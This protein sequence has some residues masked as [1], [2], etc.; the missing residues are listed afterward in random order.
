MC[1]LEDG[2]FIIG[3]VIARIPVASYEVTEVWQICQG[4]IAIQT[5]CDVYAKLSSRQ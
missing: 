4:V 1:S 5:K 3:L 2:L